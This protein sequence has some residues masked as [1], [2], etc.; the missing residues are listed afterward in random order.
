MAIDGKIFRIDCKCPMCK[1]FYKDTSPVKQKRIFYQYCQVCIIK[2]RSIVDKEE[3][4]LPPLGSSGLT[5][6]AMEE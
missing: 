4:T 2:V 6:G 3:Q 5:R 1:K